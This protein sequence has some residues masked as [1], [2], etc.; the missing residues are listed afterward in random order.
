MATSKNVIEIT[1]VNGEAEITLYGTVYTIRIKKA[2]K[3][4]EDKAEKA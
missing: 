4:A 3:K 1:P 2:D